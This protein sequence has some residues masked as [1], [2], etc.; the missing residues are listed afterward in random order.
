M[1]NSMLILSICLL[2]ISNGVAQK[3]K[4]NVVIMLADNMGYGDLGVYGGGEIRG[5]PTPNIDQL[6]KEGMQLTQFFVEQ[7]CTP[8]RAALMTGKYSPRTGL[9]SIIVAGTPSTLQSEEVTLAEVFKQNGYNTGMVG[10]WHLGQEKQSLPIN[11]GFD[12][13][14]VGILETTDGTLYPETMRRSGFTEEMISKSQPYIWESEPG[15]D[16]LKKVRVYDLEYRR[17][18]EGDIANASVDYINKQAK[19][20]KPFFLYVGWSHVHY[21]GLSH[22]DFQGKSTSGPYGDMVM[23]LDYRTGQILQALK[24]SGIEDNTIV[25]WISDNGPVQAQGTNGDFMGS[26]PGPFRG[27]IGDVLEGSLRVPGMIKWPKKITPGVSNEM[28]SIHDFFPSLTTMIGSKYSSKT[29]IDGVDQSDFFTGKSDK[30]AR[31]S[32]ITFIDNEIASV[33]WKHWR[34]YPKQILESDGNPSQMGVGSYR[35]DGVGYPAIYNI[36]QDP[37]E[38]WN[39]IGFVAWVIAPYLK[40]ISEYNKSLVDFP[41]PAPF[42]LTEFN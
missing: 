7:G 3:N 28:V 40:I 26:S 19:S 15:K 38:Q 10:K 4:P 18:I 24:D 22:P 35:V 34:C 23:E 8:S 14:H 9:N 17:L 31:E 20:K 1:R 6:A 41:N 39:Q 25:V 11:Q 32:L 33:R 36:K 21:P 42:S 2:F 16:E 29:P 5:M 27:E 37:R 12:E 13:Y 30:S